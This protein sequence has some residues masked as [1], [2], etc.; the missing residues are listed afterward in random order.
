MLLAALVSLLAALGSLLAALGALL[1]A[2]G[3]SGLGTFGFT[4]VRGLGSCE[5][6]GFPEVLG[7]GRCETSGFIMVWS[8][9]GRERTWPSRGSGDGF[10]GDGGGLVGGEASYLTAI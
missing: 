6:C 1:A 7:L 8:P 5:T 9:P 2:L 3:G 4:V 10:W